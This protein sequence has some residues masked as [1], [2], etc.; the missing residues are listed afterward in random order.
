MQNNCTE[1]DENAKLKNVKPYCRLKVKTNTLQKP[2]EA[3]LNRGFLLWQGMLCYIYFDALE[4]LKLDIQAQLARFE[5]EYRTQ[6]H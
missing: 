2:P 5:P 1:S 6:F 3:C 4:A